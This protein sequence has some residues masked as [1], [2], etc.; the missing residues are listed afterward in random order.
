M[1]ETSNRSF[2]GSSLYDY[3]YG[4]G[5]LEK[6]K[7]CLRKR[8]WIIIG[9]V[10]VVVV[11]LGLALG[12]GL[13]FGLGLKDDGTDPFKDVTEGDFCAGPYEACIVKIGN[14]GIIEPRVPVMMPADGRFR[15]GKVA[16]SAATFATGKNDSYVFGSI[17][18]GDY[19]E[20]LSA[21]QGAALEAWK[22]AALT[23][24]LPG[25][26]S[27][28][29]CMHDH[30]DPGFLM[31]FGSSL[32]HNIRKVAT[33]A[34][35]SSGPRERFMQLGTTDPGVYWGF[36]TENVSHMRTSRCGVATP[37]EAPYGMGVWFPIG[38]RGHYKIVDTGDEVTIGCDMSELRQYEDEREVVYEP[39]AGSCIIVASCACPLYGDH[40]YESNGTLHL[41]FAN[42]HTCY[43][44]GSYLRGT[45]MGTVE[46]K[47]VTWRVATPVFV[48]GVGK[49]YGADPEAFVCNQNLRVD[50]FNGITSCPGLFHSPAAY[51]DDAADQ[52]ALYVG[53]LAKLPQT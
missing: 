39:I 11:V 9:V 33:A 14:R 50:W 26:G 27:T 37:Q 16:L 51:C 44:G 35:N 42:F 30:Q 2:A 25:G 15:V 24:D 41:Q 1:G 3:S 46:A 29:R 48:M 22:T 28:I 47:L 53:G 34:G 17:L 6:D 18:D 43:I 36:F 10:A 52:D 4:Y 8:T 40:Y 49:M 20:Q 13:G 21:W 45:T 12:L 38:F 23:E 32:T 7:P 31:R 5:S 19:N